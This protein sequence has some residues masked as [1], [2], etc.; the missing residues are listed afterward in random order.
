ML[1]MQ[2]IQRI[3]LIVLLLGL[4]FGPVVLAGYGDLS[5]AQS[6]ISAHDQSIY[7]ES[8]AQRLPWMSGLYEAA[9]SA[10]LRADEY[11][12]ATTLLQNARQKSVLTPNGQFDLGKAY[13]LQG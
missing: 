1:V 2:S 8:A 7:Y 13:F 10:A 3:S 4:I 6:L 11:E 9:G 12:R 5:F